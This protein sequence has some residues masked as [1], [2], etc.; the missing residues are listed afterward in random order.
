[1][2]I[3][4]EETSI[5]DSAEREFPRLIPHPPILHPSSPGAIL[6]PP[7]STSDYIITDKPSFYNPDGSIV[8]G[9]F[10]PPHRY[11]FVDRSNPSRPHHFKYIEREEEFLLFRLLPTELRLKIWFFAL[12]GPRTLYLSSLGRISFT[13]YLS[14]IKPIDESF[15]SNRSL[16]QL[17]LV[18][19]ESK[20]LFDNMYRRIPIHIPGMG[21]RWNRTAMSDY[22]SDIS[23]GFDINGTH[24]YIDEKRDTLIID[25]RVILYAKIKSLI[26]LS[27]VSHLAI[28][29]YMVTYGLT[30]D[31]PFAN[32]QKIIEK[33][34]QWCP[35][36]KT[37]TVLWTNRG[38]DIEIPN[39]KSILHFLEIGDD[40]TSL[41]LESIDYQ[42]IF[43]GFDPLV[44][45]T[46]KLRQIKSWAGRTQEE[47]RAAIDSS[48][49]KSRLKIKTC[50]LAKI[51]G[52]CYYPQHK[53]PNTITYL[54]PKAPRFSNVCYWTE[55]P[56]CDKSGSYFMRLHDLWAQ[57]PCLF[58]GSI[59]P[60]EVD[61]DPYEGMAAMFAGCNS[62][63][64][65]E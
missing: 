50:M 34:N 57:A 43:N 30:K 38:F 1:M 13:S 47:L 33:L 19:Q 25:P 10:S 52:P 22:H 48:G 60:L 7:F 53:W 5:Q 27:R 21:F 23:N 36:L 61:E 54:L 64:D 20:N 24:S 39:T 59:I 4:T 46:Q 37:L 35:N 29:H 3:S 17:R 62:G 44:G 63:G 31:E 32:P 55:E 41:Q 65:E 18:C 15:R 26:D 12:P 2:L 11:S 14:I 28:A 40:F 49:K 58:D 16:G 45:R 9:D 8:Q 42:V 6:E 56:R 51:E